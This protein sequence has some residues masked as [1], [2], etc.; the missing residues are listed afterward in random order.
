MLDPRGHTSPAAS[1]R[2]KLIAS[3][4]HARLTLRPGQE[5]TKFIQNL[6]ELALNDLS[7]TTYDWLQ[8]HMNGYNA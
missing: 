8:K 6:V 1:R 4:V 5:Q 3:G 2:A 7:T